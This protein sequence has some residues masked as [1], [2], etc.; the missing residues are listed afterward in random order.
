VSGQHSGA[1]AARCST[2]VVAVLSGFRF[3]A[4]VWYSANGGRYTPT[5]LNYRTTAIDR[6]QQVAR[7]IGGG[8]PHGDRGSHP[9]HLAAGGRLPTLLRQ[10]YCTSDGTVLCG[11]GGK[12][13]AGVHYSLTH[14]R[15]VTSRHSRP[16][17]QLYMRGSLNKKCPWRVQRFHT[18]AVS[19]LQQYYPCCFTAAITQRSDAVEEVT[20]ASTTA[21]TRNMQGAR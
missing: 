14:T 9:N 16:L 3:M 1:P 2:T 10:L 4:D 13:S 20:K 12:L 5:H 7:Y 11:S 6:S 15:Q 8:G 18:L 19:V 17:G 21:K